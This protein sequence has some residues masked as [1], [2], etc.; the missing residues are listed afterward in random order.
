MTRENAG[1]CFHCLPFLGNL[2][3][4]MAKTL[5]NSK[6]PIEQHDQKG[7]KLPNNPP[8]S[9]VDAKS[10]AVEGKKE[11]WSKLAKNLKVEIDETQIEAY[12]R[13]VS[14]PFAPGKYGRAAVQI[15]DDRG[16]ESLKIIEL[17]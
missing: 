11:G 7:K 15:V 16:I 9:L 8:V 2:P 13:T 5:G 14:L 1:K 17:S 3:C 10:H 6:R 12:R 4:E